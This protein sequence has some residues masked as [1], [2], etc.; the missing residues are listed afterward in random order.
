MMTDGWVEV[1]VERVRVEI[2]V[3]NGKS[4]WDSQ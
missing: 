4:G 1:G 2:S 3:E